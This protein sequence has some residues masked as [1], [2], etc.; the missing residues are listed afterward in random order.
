MF[1]Y[2]FLDSYFF[3]NYVSGNTKSTFY[4]LINLNEDKYKKFIIDLEFGST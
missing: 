3:H 2:L 1:F 4:W